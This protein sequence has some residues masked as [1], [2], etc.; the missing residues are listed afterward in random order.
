VPWARSSENARSRAAPR[1][2]SK[3]RKP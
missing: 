2:T 1:N 3:E